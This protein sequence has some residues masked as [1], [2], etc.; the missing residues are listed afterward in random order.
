MG[1]WLKKVHECRGEAP[2]KLT[3]LGFV[4]FVSLAS[5]RFQ[6][7][8]NL[9]IE[10]VAA[11]DQLLTS[12]DWLDCVAQKLGTDAKALLANGYLELHDLEE[13]AG[14]NT[15]LVVHLIRHTPAWINRPSSIKRR[16]DCNSEAVV[17][18]QHVIHTATAATP[19]WLA[20]RDGFYSHLMRCRVCHAPSRRY[21]SEGTQLRQTYNRMCAEDIL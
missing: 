14:C 8:V 5:G 9:E 21:C 10:A 17:E 3:E 6:K 18:S 11:N 15:D 2:T 19:E 1:R 12:R 4:G 20:V 16:T 7:K 13:C